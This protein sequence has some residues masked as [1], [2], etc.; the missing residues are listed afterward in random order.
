MSKDLISVI[1]PTFNRAPYIVEAIESVLQQSFS[2]V[3][4]IVVDDGCTDG[5][6][7]ILA[8]YEG[9]VIC[10][11]QGNR[12]TGAARNAGILRSRG[13]YLAFLDDDDVWVPGKLDRQMQ[14]FRRTPQLEAIYGHVEQFISPDLDARSASRLRHLHRRVQPAPIPSSLLIRR[15]SFDRVGL[16]DESLRLG[17]EVDWHA[18]LQDCELNTVMLPDV[19]YRRRL[20]GS[21]QNLTHAGEGVERLKVLKASLDRRRKMK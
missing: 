18:R 7:E 1:I 19:L 13:D 8:D 2:P 17:V 4:I 20:H 12:G 9:K 10:I 21:N 11:R 15:S 16:F 6:S 14:C 3:E 5:T